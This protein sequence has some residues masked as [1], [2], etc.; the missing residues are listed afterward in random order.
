LWQGAYHKFGYFLHLAISQPA[1]LAYSTFKVRIQFRSQSQFILV[2][3]YQ[4]Q[5][6]REIQVPIHQEFN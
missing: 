1:I 5:V 4:S 3:L 6:Q 2:P